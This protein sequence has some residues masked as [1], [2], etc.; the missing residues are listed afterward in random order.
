MRTPP[1]PRRRSARRPRPALGT[2]LELDPSAPVVAG[3]P[4][5][6]SGNKIEPAP[7]GML[8]IV[9]SCIGRRRPAE[10]TVTHLGIG[11][12]IKWPYCGYHAWQYKPRK[13]R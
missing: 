4:D 13:A 8:C 10:V 7:P 1:P 11:G 9:S 5:A 6:S 3:V 12:R 2:T